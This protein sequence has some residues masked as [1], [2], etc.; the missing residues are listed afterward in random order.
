MASAGPSRYGAS[1]ELQIVVTYGLQDGVCLKARKVS[2]E[3]A[4][5]LK[6]SGDAQGLLP[7]ERKQSCW[8]VDHDLRPPWQGQS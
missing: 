8:D 6:G 5:N 4:V 7:V 1:G 2:K 3:G